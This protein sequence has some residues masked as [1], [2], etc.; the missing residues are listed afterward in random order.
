MNAMLAITNGD[1]AADLLADAGLAPRA[2][3]LPW[4]DMLHVGRLAWTQTLAECSAIRVPFLVDGL[5]S[6]AA[7]TAGFAERDAVMADH[8]QWDHIELWFE[9]DLYDQLQLVQI[10]D[11]FAR[12]GH[13]I[14]RLFLVQADDFLGHQTADTVLRFA[15]YREPITDVQL[16]CASRAWNA[17]TAATPEPAAALTET[18]THT[19]PFLHPALRRFLE[20]LPSARTGLT[21]TQAT[22]LDLVCSGI[23]RPGR[24]FGQ[25]QAREEAQFMGDL[26]FFRELDAMTFCE[27]PLL[28]GLAGHFHQ[29]PEAHLASHLS[30][31][32]FG[33]A[34]AAGSA[35]YLAE[36]TLDRWWG[37]THLKMRNDWRWDAETER[38]QK[39]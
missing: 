1:S 9:H 34:V 15:H 30:V 4:R 14:E 16:A 32:P 24:L 35:D 22:I 11:Y 6:M 29:G 19:L 17:L 18:D 10:L 8:A 20:E 36:N 38:L 33:N 12:S 7:V 2:N 37:G 26:P 39:R 25:A 13:R 31:T 5:H 27:T 23:D 28:S 21:R 3:I